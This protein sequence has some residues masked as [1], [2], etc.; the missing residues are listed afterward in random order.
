MVPAF[1]V[2]RYPL[3]GI[4]MGAGWG[5]PESP[6]RRPATLF[7]APDKRDT[8]RIGAMPQEDVETIRA[9]LAAVN[10]RDVEGMLS[11]LH[12]DAEMVPAK[13]VLEGSVY[14]GHEGLR[15]WVDE[16][17]EDWDD[18]HID[19]HEV[20]GLEEGRVLVLGRFQARG[21]SGVTMDQPAAWICE[22][23]AGKVARIRFYADADAALAAAAPPA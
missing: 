18:F 20:R 23:T 11:T 7:G 21:K 16:M 5:P 13:A 10:R 17:A 2:Q 4:P 9:G 22:L 15:R 6:S 3:D 19:P 1:A 14:R 12:P 8:A